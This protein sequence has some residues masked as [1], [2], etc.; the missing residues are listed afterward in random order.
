MSHAKYLGIPAII[1][2]RG[3]NNGCRFCAISKMWRSN[4]RP[5]EAVV[6]ELK[7][8]KTNKVIFFDPNFFKPRSMPWS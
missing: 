7:S 5:I 6:D 2:D 3:C 8:L 4:P 1:A